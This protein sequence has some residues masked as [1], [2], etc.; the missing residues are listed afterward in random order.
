[1]LS[2]ERRT[3]RGR[4]AYGPAAALSVATV[5]VVGAVTLVD[6]R[7]AELLVSE[8]GP[9]EWLQVVLFAGAALISAQLAALEWSE[10]RSGAPDLLFSASFALLAIS[11]MELP[12][13]LLGK[14]IRI[15]RLARDV[16]AGLP[17]ESI[18]V[19]VT[20]VLVVG[21][22]VY[23][24]RHRAELVAWGRPALG[25]AWGRL[26]LLAASILV[27]TELFE[28]PLNHLVG[29]D[30]PRSLLEETLELLAA[31]YCF[32]ALMQRRGRP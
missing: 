28:R 18:F 1:M 10:R 29:P 22:G 23:A 26:L 14:S 25:T 9:I 21:L 5:A 13:L 24:L 19:L 8:H 30:L 3:R 20:A 4:S 6:G 16:A 7:L 15:R 17:R 12:R 11:E 2:G 31:L 27:L 32:L